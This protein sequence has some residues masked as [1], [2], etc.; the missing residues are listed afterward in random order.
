[1][2]TEPFEKIEDMENPQTAK[3]VPIGWLIFYVGAILWGIYY[4]ASYT[5]AF[6]GWT[7]VKAYEQSIDQKVR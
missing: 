1:M 4:V 6:S 5:P 7:Q 2:K 3:R